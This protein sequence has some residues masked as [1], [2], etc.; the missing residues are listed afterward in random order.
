M[1]AFSNF[2][3]F[4]ASLPLQG[5]QGLQYRDWGASTKPRRC[6]AARSRKVALLDA[7][8]DVKC[9]V[10]RC[11][12]LT[13]CSRDCLVVTS[14][15]T[16]LHAPPHSVSTLWLYNPDVCLQFIEVKFRYALNSWRD[17]V[18]SGQ[19]MANLL[20]HEQ[21]FVQL[22][23]CI[24]QFRTTQTIS[25]RLFSQV[26]GG[27][28]DEWTFSRVEKQFSLPAQSCLGLGWD[29]CQKL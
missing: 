26:S 10:S 20:L 16:M 23:C 21:Q 12:S 8:C 17:N 9:L 1:L 2:Q 3:C 7:A 4:R 28:R 25:H 29:C 19:T 6:S 15:G 11:S 24:L 18:F 22:P 13:S 27:W 14:S 5:L